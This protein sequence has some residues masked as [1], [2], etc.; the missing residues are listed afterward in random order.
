MSPSQVI[1]LNSPSQVIMLNVTSFQLLTDDEHC[2]ETQAVTAHS[3][4]LFVRFHNLFLPK[5]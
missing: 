4:V 5:K 3:L 1:M 2:T